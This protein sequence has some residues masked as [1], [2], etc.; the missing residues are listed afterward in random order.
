[1]HHRDTNSSRA[2]DTGLA[3]V[4]LLLIVVFLKKSLLLVPVAI[5]VLFITMLVP[6]CFSLIAPVWFGFSH[7][8]GNVVSKVF[9]SLVFLI[10]ATP[11]GLMRKI[12]GSDSMNLS[13]WKK[14]NQSVFIARNQTFSP[15]D[16]EKPF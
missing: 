10:I 3:L 14:S 15:K 2:K 4:F 7:L 12:I 8:L 16:L 13:Q 9:F 11:V 5:V 1:M 6:Q